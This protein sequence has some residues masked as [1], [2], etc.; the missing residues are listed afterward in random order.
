MQDVKDEFDDFQEGSQ[1]LEAELEA[2][3]E[4]YEKRVKEL[5]STRSALEE[6]NELLKVTTAF[7]V[8]FNMISCKCIAT[9]C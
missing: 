8:W 7:A 2:Q 4:Q 5:V 3:L 6:E 9:I 1:E